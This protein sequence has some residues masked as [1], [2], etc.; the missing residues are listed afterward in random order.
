MFRE[1]HVTRAEFFAELAM[2]V[3]AEEVQWVEFIDSVYDDD[4]EE[5]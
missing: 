5:I 4:E 3:P 2:L 1:A